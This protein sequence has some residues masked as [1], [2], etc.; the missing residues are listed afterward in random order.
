MCVY[1]AGG[2]TLSYVCDI[3]TEHTLVKLEVTSGMYE[4]VI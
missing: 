2:S 1:R 3:L 4:I